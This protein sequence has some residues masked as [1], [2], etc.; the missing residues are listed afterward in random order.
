MQ[1]HS[2][3]PFRTHKDFLIYSLIIFIIIYLFPYFYIR[4]IWVPYQMSMVKDFIRI[5]SLL[6]AALM[7][8][9]QIYM[10][11]WSIRR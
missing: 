6:K 5:L 11:F 7:E 8:N 4:K 9:A 2:K 10:G 1:C 3:L